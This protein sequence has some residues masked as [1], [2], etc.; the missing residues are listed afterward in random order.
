MSSQSARYYAGIG[1]RKTPENILRIMS[2][3][4]SQLYEM[5]YTLRSGGAPGADQ[6]FEFGVAR[7]KGEDVQEKVEIYLP[8]HTFEKENRSSIQP[9]RIQPQFEAFEI[10][11][12]YHPS[13]RFLS[14]GAKK[15]H[16]RNVHQIYGH[17]V[18]NPVYSEFV[19]CWTEGK[20]G[21]GG[22]GQAI[23]IANDLEIPVFD[24]AGEEDIEEIL[25]KIN[26]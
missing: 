6:A 15:L 10:A 21:G 8:W 18:T 23:R 17:D 3:A 26:G 22:T 19:I 5:G 25:E 20:R 1:S 9:K 7:T 12:R 13:W 11:E 2:Y 24:L 16:A 14:Q 4:A